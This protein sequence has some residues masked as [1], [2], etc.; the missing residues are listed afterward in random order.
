VSVPTTEDLL[1]PI[2][3]ELRE[4]ERRLEETVAGDAGPMAEAMNHI[5]RAGG[6]R[7]RPALVILSAALGDARTDDVYDLAMAIEFIH[8][9]TLIHDDVIDESPTRRGIPTIH[10]VLGQNP[11]IIV[12]DYYFAKGANL[13]ANIGTPQIDGIVSRTV[14]TVCMGELLQLT[15]KRALD[16]STEEYYRKIERKTAALLAACCYTGA[17]LGGLDDVRA[18]A[19]QRYG[20]ALGM[21]FQI[22]DDVLDYVATAAEVGKPV[23]ADLRQGTITLPLMY[24][25]QDGTL[26]PGLRALLEREPMRDQD[27]DAVVR[28]VRESPAVARSEAH[29]HRFADKARGELSG[30]PTS[31]A[32][33]TLESVCDYVVERKICGHLERAELLQLPAECRRPQPEEEA[34]RQESGGLR[35][36][37]EHRQRSAVP[38][39]HACD[40]RGRDHREP[41]GIQQRNDADHEQA[42]THGAI[43]P[44]QSLAKHG[45]RLLLGLTARDRWFRDVPPQAEH[46]ER[47]EQRGAPPRDDGDRCGPVGQQGREPAERV[48]RVAKCR[49]V[50]LHPDHGHAPQ[51]RRAGCGGGGRE[52]QREGGAAGHR[53]ASALTMGVHGHIGTTGRRAPRRLRHC[54]VL[55]TYA[56][57]ASSPHGR[58]PP[59]P[60]HDLQHPARCARSRAAR[61]RR[62]RPLG[63][64]CARPAGGDR[65]GAGPASRTAA[66]SHPHGREAERSRGGQ[67]QRRAEP[68]AGARL[69]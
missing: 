11:A 43:L 53:E 39:R 4:F 25:L 52:P 50:L 18:E 2:S 42:R 5:V 37:R 51:Q 61:H 14:M 49:E 13:M 24:A 34:R 66:R 55:R 64:G 69:A 19:L 20:F 41:P 28:L 23:G 45:G 44:A 29:A 10:A 8:T 9:A 17:I 63:S 46:G 33:T 57:I 27:Y 12:G 38:G 21:A 65:S 30:F 22:A 67:A 56:P 54:M 15:S 47:K 6:K 62:H 68:V 7:L 32:R 16:Q 35:E 40:R 58:L 48:T 1:A 3:T 60:G 59:D 36:Q 26:G 31:S